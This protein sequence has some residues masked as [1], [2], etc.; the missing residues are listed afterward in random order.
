MS[1]AIPQIIRNFDIEINNG[2]TEWKNECWWFVKPEYK[3][4][5]KPIT[6]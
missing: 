4:V 6:V 2:D 3:A 1:K 5:V